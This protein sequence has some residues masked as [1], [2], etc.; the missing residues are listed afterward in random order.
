M[1]DA[2]VQSV[3]EG[4]NL[5]DN[6]VQP[7]HMSRNNLIVVIRSK[8]R[9]YVVPNCNADTEWSEEF[10]RCH[11]NDE[12]SRFTKSRATALIRAH[13]LQRVQKTEYGVRELYLK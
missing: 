6:F 11:V 2:N 9:W 4:S 1:L 5:Q 12:S 7:T 8:G 10:A 3:P 13:N